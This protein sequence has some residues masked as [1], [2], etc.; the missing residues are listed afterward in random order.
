MNR[1]SHSLASKL[2]LSILLLAGTFFVVSLGILFTQSRFI[3]RKEARE[4]ATSVLDTS[5][6]RLNRYLT[7]VET[8]VN[9]NEWLVTENMQPDSLLKYS[10]MITIL[11]GNV[12]GCSITAEP[13]LFPEYGRYFSAYSILQGDSVVT[14]REEP[15]DYYD[16]VWYKTSKT[17]GK[18]CW[19][20][21]FDDYNEGTLSAEERIASYCKPIFSPDS[22]MVG[23]I[24]CDVALHRLAEAINYKQPYPHSYYI[25]TGENGNFFIHPDSTKL[26]N[27]TIFSDTDPRRDADIIALGYEMTAGKEGYMQIDI[28]GKRYLVCYKP[29]EGTSWSLALIIPDSD[30]LKNY[31]RLS[32]ILVALVVIGLIVIMLLCRKNV[33]VAVSPLNQLLLQAQRIADGHYDEQIPRTHRPDAIGRLQNSFATMQE[34]LNH[35]IRD[36]RE[37]NEE[38]TR[39]NQQLAEATKMAEEAAH[40]KTLFIQNMTHQIR[41]P[42]NIIIGFAQVI[43]DSFGSAAKAEEQI[44]EDEVK[45]IA[46]MMQRN[47][48]SLHR[49]LLMLYD[50]SDEGLAREKA[51]LKKENVKCNQLARECIEESLRR[52]PGLPIAFTTDVADDFAIHTSRVYLTRTVLEL[53]YNAEKYS[54][55][56]HITLSV[57]CKGD[58]V[59]FTVEDTG[60]GMDK[61]YLDQMYETFTKV[62]DLSE[63]LGLGLS[64]CRRHARN[65]GGDI[66]LD[67]DYHE[68]CRFVVELPRE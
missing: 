39:R 37:A 64:L 51:S 26:F 25:M 54:D 10:R 2:S 61:D 1:I 17:L 14:V 52:F 66:T 49:M 59:S 41:T 9:A 7:T 48:V 6:E 24:S 11:N 5:M 62:N 38:A 18:A 3:L 21:P 65:L 50:S 47:T 33:C 34:S 28:D 58:K 20:D 13:D 27:K 60:P 57:G 46:D 22:Q 55:K 31:Y 4:K 56:Q 42:L 32:Y 53:L 63:G 29:V 40:Q 12:N 68:G 23:V 19:V 36:I 16:K 35:H 45:S 8:A 67:P 30:I 43:R 15:Y 44:A